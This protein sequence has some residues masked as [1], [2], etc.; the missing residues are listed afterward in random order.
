MQDD[1]ATVSRAV[2][3]GAASAIPGFS[4]ALAAELGMPVEDGV[5][6]GAPDGV[7]PG[8]LTVAAGLALDEALA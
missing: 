2:M 1:T 3:T 4:A 6:P 8:R 5:V 7:D